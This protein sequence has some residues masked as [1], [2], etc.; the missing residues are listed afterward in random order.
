MAAGR[1]AIDIAGCHRCVPGAM[2][3]DLDI[4]VVAAQRIDIGPEE[5]SGEV[6]SAAGERSPHVGV[7]TQQRHQ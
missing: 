2:R 7:G 1:I 4:D 6:R 3:H 5:V